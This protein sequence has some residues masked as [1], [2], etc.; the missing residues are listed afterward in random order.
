MTIPPKQFYI[1]LGSCLLTVVLFAFPGLY[2]TIKDIRAQ[3]AQIM[4][5][6]QIVSE[7]LSWRANDQTTLRV[8]LRGVC[9]TVNI[10]EK[11]DHPERRRFYMGAKLTN[12][13]A[14]PM[15]ITS[16]SY[17]MSLDDV[18][19]VSQSFGPFET[20]VIPAGESKSISSATLLDRDVVVGLFEG[21]VKLSARAWFTN[22]P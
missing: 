7:K 10:A 8:E 3:N 18:E 11:G 20:I 12:E 15:Q 17:T 1:L 9:G 4:A 19:L 13:T 22:E 5:P 6:V 2:S 14:K 16:L 21:S